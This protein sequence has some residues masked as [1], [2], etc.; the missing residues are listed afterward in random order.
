MIRD[1]GQTLDIGLFIVYMA[2]KKRFIDTIHDKVPH[3][4]VR[5]CQ[6]K[7]F[8]EIQFNHI[9]VF[10]MHMIEFVQSRPGNGEHGLRQVESRDFNL[11]FSAC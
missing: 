5:E 6:V 3:T 10:Q 9:L 1:S 11:I 2:D 8:F 4:A 7:L